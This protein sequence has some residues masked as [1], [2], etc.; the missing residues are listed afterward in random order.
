MSQFQ[1]SL[2]LATRIPNIHHN[3]FPLSESASVQ[4]R[5]L[6]SSC[7]LSKH[8]KTKTGDYRFA[9][10][11]LYGHETWSFFLREGHSLRVFKNRMFRKILEPKKKKKEN[12]GE[13]CMIN[14][15]ICALHQI[16][17]S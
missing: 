4:S 6:L 16:L 8:L 10:A 12:S 9:A 11:F 17:C 3:A 2:F 1:S 5:I 14:S 13:N 15:I 7:L